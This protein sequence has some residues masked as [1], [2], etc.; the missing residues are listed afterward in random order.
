[1]IAVI[2]WKAQATIYL[3]NRALIE[4]FEWK[5]DVAPNEPRKYGVV[6]VVFVST[7]LFGSGVLSLATTRYVWV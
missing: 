4:G 5:S 1:L 7:L 2:Y 6:A 3:K